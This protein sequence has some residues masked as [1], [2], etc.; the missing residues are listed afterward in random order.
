MPLLPIYQTRST[1][2]ARSLARLSSFP[3]ITSQLGR[4][5]SFA[6]FGLDG[7][8]RQ[9]WSSLSAWRICTHSLLYF[10]VCL[11]HCMYIVYIYDVCISDWNVNTPCMHLLCGIVFSPRERERDTEHR[12]RQ[13]AKLPLDKVQTHKTHIHNSHSS[14]GGGGGCCRHIGRNG[15]AMPIRYDIVYDISICMIYCIIYVMLWCDV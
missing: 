7:R 11:D 2:L 14:G 6:S 5:L 4:V 8:N 9:L 15:I 10:I 12:R 3:T 1:P 13:I